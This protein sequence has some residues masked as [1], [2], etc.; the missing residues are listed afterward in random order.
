MKIYQTTFDAISGVPNHC[1]ARL[2][3]LT[4][5]IATLYMDLILRRENGNRDQDLGNP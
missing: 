4:Q 5:V 1:I 2:G 3:D